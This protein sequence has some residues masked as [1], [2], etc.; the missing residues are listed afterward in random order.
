MDWSIYQDLSSTKSRKKWIYRRQKHLD[1]S[2]IYQESFSQTKSSEI[3]ALW[4]K[5]LSRFYLRRNPKT[6]M[7][8]VLLRSIEKRRKK[9]SIEGNL[10]RIYR[11]A[12]ELEKKWVFQR[13]E[14]HIE[15]NATSKLLK[16]RS[17]Q[18]INLSKHLSTY[19]QSIQDPKHTHTHTKQ[20]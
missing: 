12:V 15:M 13:R 3:L 19:K 4:I 5:K 11:E 2:R 8:R 9:S 10:S 14:K 18:H 1:G 20:V 17:N 6:S 16:H 7:N